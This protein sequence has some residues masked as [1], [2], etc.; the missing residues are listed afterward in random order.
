M[1]ATIKGQTNELKFNYRALFKANAEFSEIDDKGN[2]L[3]DGALNL[4]NRVLTNDITVIPDLIKVAGGFGKLSDD[5]LFDAVE[6]L[7]NGGDDIEQVMSDL[8]DEMKNSGFFNQAISAQVKQSEEFMPQ[9]KAMAENDQQMKMQ[10]PAI[11]RMTA[12][13]KE[14]L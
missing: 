10:L 12:L 9:M 2:R 1:Q 5:D 8:K 3:K 4:F 7:T 13:V 11:K 14:N 6:E